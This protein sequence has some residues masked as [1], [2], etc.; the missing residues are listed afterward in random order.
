VP[1]SAV[2]RQGPTALSLRLSIIVR[3]AILE[4]VTQRGVQLLLGELESAEAYAGGVEV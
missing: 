2:H 3:G 1:P 4:Q